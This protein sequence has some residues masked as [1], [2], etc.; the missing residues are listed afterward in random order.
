MAGSA[1]ES[2]PQRFL[3]AQAAEGLAHFEAGGHF[4]TTLRVGRVV[5]YAVG[6]EPIHRALWAWRVAA[7]MDDHVYREFATTVL[8]RVAN[9]SDGAATAS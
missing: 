5:H 1:I 8:M 6:L 4:V 2:E 9:Q 7:C 3:A